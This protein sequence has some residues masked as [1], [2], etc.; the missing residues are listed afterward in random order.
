MIATYFELK[1]KLD[2]E[3]SLIYDTEFNYSF[4]EVINYLRLELEDF[5]Y[6]HIEWEHI[7]LEAF[8]SNLS[9]LTIDTLIKLALNFD[10]AND[11]NDWILYMQNCS[12]YSLYEL[13]CFE[14]HYQ[15]L[16]PFEENLENF[17]THLKQ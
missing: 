15:S 7:E 2:K 13:E 8:T 5:L 6:N 14:E 1:D 17:L 11:F 10:Y 3:K 12:D 4:N 16:L 9:E